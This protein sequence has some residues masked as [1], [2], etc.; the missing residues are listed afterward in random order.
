[1]SDNVPV[2]LRPE[3]L[4]RLE[5]SE[6]EEDVGGLPAGAQISDGVCWTAPTPKRSSLIREQGCLSLPASGVLHASRDQC[7]AAQAHEA[8]AAILPS[9]KKVFPVGAFRKEPHQ[10]PPSTHLLDRRLLST[11]ARAPHGPGCQG[12]SARSRPTYRGRVFSPQT[13]FDAGGIGTTT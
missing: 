13:F 8:P 10:A 11:P 1:M 9:T 3:L 5:R 4:Q 6:S 12:K 7:P 2:T